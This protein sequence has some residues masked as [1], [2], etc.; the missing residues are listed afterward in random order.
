MGDSTIHGL[1][2]GEPDTRE[3]QCDLL[4]IKSSLPNADV[5]DFGQAQRSEFR[6]LG[7]AKNVRY[8]PCRRFVEV[9]RQHSA[10]IKKDHPYLR[11]SRAASSWRSTRRSSSVVGVRPFAFPLKLPTGSDE[12]GRMTTR[13]PMSTTTTSSAFQRARTLAGMEIWPFDDTFMTKLTGALSV[14]LYEVMI[15]LY[16]AWKWVLVRIL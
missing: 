9:E 16:V 10:G 13:L 5:D 7:A 1:H 6:P 12:R 8:L 4:F 15:S 11:R 3:V 14:S 2:F